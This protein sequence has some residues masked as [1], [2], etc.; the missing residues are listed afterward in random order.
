MATLKKLTRI[1]SLI[2]QTLF[3]KIAAYLYSLRKGM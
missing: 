1:H 3:Q 2:L